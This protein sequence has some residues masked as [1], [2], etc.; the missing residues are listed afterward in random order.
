MSVRRARSYS[1]NGK[2]SVQHMD[3]CIGFE[4]NKAIIISIVM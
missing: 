1:R 4:W 2:V 3:R